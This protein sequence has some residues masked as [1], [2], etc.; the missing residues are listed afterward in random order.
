MKRLIIE[1]DE[2]KCN[3]C[4]QCVLD[5]AEGALAIVDGKA[6][7]VSDV[8]CDGLGACLNCPQGALKLTE[9]EAAPFDEVAAL[10]AKDGSAATAPQ[11]PPAVAPH[12][13]CPGAAA[14]TLRPLAAP[15]ADAP[16]ELTARLPSWP[17]QLRLVQPSA[18]FLRGAHVLLA[19]HCAGFAL[20]GLHQDWLTGRIP[21]IACPKLEDNALL[22]ERLTALLAAGVQSLTVLRMS[23][24]CCGGLE[25]L[26]RNAAAGLNLPVSCAVVR[27]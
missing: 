6:K 13:G 3:G 16:A 12:R 18:P 11:R 14:R 5:C 1:I 8:F 7:L 19:A 23:V 21:I 25:R 2:D 24:P 9:R 20:P 15:V 26:A 22:Q 10:A 17:I 4:G 27:L